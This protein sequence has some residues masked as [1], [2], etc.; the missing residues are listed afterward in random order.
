ML[1]VGTDSWPTTGLELVQFV[2]R[3]LEAARAN[4]L[5]TL[6]IRETLVSKVESHT[7]F[8]E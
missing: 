4:A 5:A 2:K 8:D 3:G 1:P 6:S 7:G